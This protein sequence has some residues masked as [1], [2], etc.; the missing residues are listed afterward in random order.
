MK[1]LHEINKDK[2][3]KL[4]RLVIKVQVGDDVFTAWYYFNSIDKLFA[5]KDKIIALYDDVVEVNIQY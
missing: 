4:C 5:S 2:T 1:E 3:K